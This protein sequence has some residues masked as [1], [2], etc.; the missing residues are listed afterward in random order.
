MSM[1]TVHADINAATAAA[2]GSTPVI[3]G[4]TDYTDLSAG[5]L[6]FV[7]QKVVFQSQSQLVLGNI[8]PSRN[9]GTIFFALHTRRNTGDGGRN[10]LLDT[11]L[12]SFRSKRIGSATCLNAAVRFTGLSENW[13]ITGIEVPFYFDQTS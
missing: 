1:T 5:Q 7:T 4:N 2:L 8:G 12:N 10:A 11:V 13:A 6:D 3:Y 9:R